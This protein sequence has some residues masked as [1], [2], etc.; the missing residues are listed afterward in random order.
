MKVIKSLLLLLDRKW[1]LLYQENAVASTKNQS[2]AGIL[3]PKLNE[4]MQRFSYLNIVLGL[5][6]ITLYAF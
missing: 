1:D 5:Q 2:F 4:K 3:M 6:E